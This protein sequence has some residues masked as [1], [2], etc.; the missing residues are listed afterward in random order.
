M[1]L[2]WKVLIKSYKKINNEFWKF[3]HSNNLVVVRRKWN[4]LGDDTHNYSVSDPNNYR[5][6]NHI[7]ECGW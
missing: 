2:T 7:I 6:I 4:Y 3:V 1:S 5:G